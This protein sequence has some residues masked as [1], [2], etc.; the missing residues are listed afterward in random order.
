MGRAGMFNC[1]VGGEAGSSE[2]Q[3]R[4]KKAT[5]EGG[6][7]AAAEALNAR[8]IWAFF[9]YILGFPGESEASMRAT[10]EEARTIALR[11]PHAGVQVWPFRPIPGTEDYGRA[12]E[13]G[14]RPPENLEGWSDVDVFW[15]Q[16]P[17]PECVPPHVERARRLLM[18]YV[19]LAQ[20]APRARR[21]W[22]ER[23]A[24]RRLERGTWERGRWEAR[25]FHLVQGVAR[26]V[27][28]AA[29]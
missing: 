9:T 7:L 10:L 15:N 16:L 17:W 18:H 6:N 1:L 14:Y 3:P 19:A 4:I 5:R 23:R 25:A 22:W 29:G 24:R 21:G 8:G 28:G 27:R 13:L 12:L 11:C 20:G 2:T 26:S